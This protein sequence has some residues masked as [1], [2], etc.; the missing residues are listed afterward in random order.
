MQSRENRYHIGDAMVTS[1]QP[2]NQLENGKS[3][4]DKMSTIVWKEYKAKRR[5]ENKERKKSSNS[6]RG[7]DCEIG[8]RWQRRLE[9]RGGSCSGP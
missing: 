1:T 7:K 4:D 9:K 5:K 6:R 3:Q 8:S 2:R